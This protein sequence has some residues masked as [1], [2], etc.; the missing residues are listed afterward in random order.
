MAR[1]L[2]AVLALV[3]AQACVTVAPNIDLPEVPVG[4]DAALQGTGA[5]LEDG[6]PAAY[7]GTLAGGEAPEQPLA[8]PTLPQEPDAGTV[9]APA[10][11]PV[12]AV[13]EP[14]AGQDAGPSVCVDTQHLAELLC[15]GPCFG[16]C[17]GVCRVCS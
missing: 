5:L 8:A 2:A 17:T 1:S 4:E 15:E 6:G 11:A 12:A 16:T 3:A 7:L 10:S 9:G 14:D 13:P